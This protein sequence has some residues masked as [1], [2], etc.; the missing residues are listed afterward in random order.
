[1]VSRSDTNPTALIT[2][3]EFDQAFANPTEELNR[4]A[5]N[6]GTRLHTEKADSRGS[7]SGAKTRCREETVSQVAGT[8]TKVVEEAHSLGV[9]E[10]V[11]QAALDGLSE[12]LTDV[13]SNTSHETTVAL[14]RAD[15]SAQEAPR[16]NAVLNEADKCVEDLNE[17]LQKLETN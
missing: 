12:I 9:K 6:I 14:R 15:E 2:R 11:I 16:V 7:A 13:A 17:R 10:K 1:M 3:G 4:T 8:M 5:Q